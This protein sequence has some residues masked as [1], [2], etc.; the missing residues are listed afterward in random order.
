[1]IWEYELDVPQFQSKDYK[2]NVISDV[3]GLN[4]QDSEDMAKQEFK[5]EVDINTLVRRFHLTGEMP[6]GVRMP[7]YG[8]FIGI[9]SYHDAANAIAMAGEAF[10]AM[11]AEVRERFGND[12]AAFVDFCL[13]PENIGEARKMGLAPEAELLEA[14][15]LASRPPSSPAEPATSAAGSGGSGA[16]AS[17]GTRST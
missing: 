3:T 12:P 11:P 6:Q 13:N 16:P 1:M 5:E 4:C 14:E 8:D 9:G 17:S 15:D 10:D 7:E 2:P